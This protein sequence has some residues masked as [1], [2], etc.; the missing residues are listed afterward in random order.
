MWPNEGA[1]LWRPEAGPELSTVSDSTVV[2]KQVVDRPS[3]SACRACSESVHRECEIL[4][5]AGAFRG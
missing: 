5:K 2:E 3:Q 1:M 4:G